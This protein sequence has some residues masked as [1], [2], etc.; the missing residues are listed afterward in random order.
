MDVIKE[1]VWRTFLSQIRLKL[2]NIS[3]EEIEKIVEKVQNTS[4]N[5]TCEEAKVKVYITRFIDEAKKIVGVM[6]DKQAE[7][8]QCEELKSKQEPMVEK[9]ESKSLLPVEAVAEKEVE[10]SATIEESNNMIMKNSVEKVVLMAGMHS[11][12]I[13]QDKIP[14]TT[15]LE[16]DAPTLCFG[17]QVIPIISGNA[18][19]NVIIDVNVAKGRCANH[20]TSMPFLELLENY[21]TVIDPGYEEYEKEQYVI[22]RKARGPCFV[23]GHEGEDDKQAFL[24]QDTLMFYHNIIV[25]KDS[26]G[27]ETGLIYEIWD[28]IIDACLEDAET[29]GYSIQRDVEI[30]LAEQGYQYMFE[31]KEEMYVH[32]MSIIAQSMYLSCYIYSCTG[33]ASHISQLVGSAFNFGT[34]T[35]TKDPVKSKKD[36][37]VAVVHSTGVKMTYV[38]HSLSWGVNI[39][40]E[41]EPT[42][43][44]SDYS[45][46]RPV[47]SKH[48]FSKGNDKGGLISAQVSHGPRDEMPAPVEKVTDRKSVV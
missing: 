10:E 9:D 8:S 17:G 4:C 31:V 35:R 21:L 32:M 11:G 46:I 47:A 23:K 38:P 30:N 6:Q 3:F 15:T 7:V 41:V 42:N 24:L 43:L 16:K 2:G 13:P 26:S 5:L 45:V 44:T 20:K 36:V 1:L 48:D 33:Y 28:P 39:M 19:P 22:F 27:I 34:D 40:I 12:S 25:L 29:N 37:L 18:V 14:K